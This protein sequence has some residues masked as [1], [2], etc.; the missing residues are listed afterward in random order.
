MKNSLYPFIFLAFSCAGS[1]NEHVDKNSKSSYQIENKCPKDVDC[2]FEVLKNKSLH[3]IK[4]DIGMSYYELI[5]DPK[6]VVFK[7]SYKLITDKDLQDAGY[8]EE[9]LFETEKDYTDFNYSGKNLK[10]SKAILNVMCFCRGK[11]GTYKITE[12]EIS[13]NGKD[14]LIKI[15]SIVSNQKIEE[16][17]I[18]L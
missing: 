3:I 8:S 14:L 10:T 18:T 15:P 6:K 16:I 9:I 12:G 2:S 1:K 4:D 11:A 7:Y 5:E 17:R 13:K